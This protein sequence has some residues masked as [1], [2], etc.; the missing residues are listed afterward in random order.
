[1]C[2]NTVFGGAVHLPCS[3]LN[4]KRNTLVADN[5]CMKRLIH[6]RL[7]SGNIVLEASGNGLEHIVNYS[8]TVVTVDNVVNDNS[9]G[10]DV[11][12]LVEA[13]ALHIHLT[14]NSVNT[15]DSAGNTAV[16]HNL[17]DPVADLLLNTVK[18]LFSLGLLMLKLFLNF[19]V[20]NGIKVTDRQILKL[21]LYA[22]DTETVS[23]RSIYF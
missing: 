22:S 3:D 7:G 8:E 16:G 6:I 15:L 9:D 20:G 12:N 21:L 23:D 11:V 5:R 2:G 18:V 19:L 10:I 1:M 17:L 13:L 4:L 14:V